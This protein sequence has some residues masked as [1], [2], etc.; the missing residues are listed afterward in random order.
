[1]V[2]QLWL[3]FSKMYLKK[4]EKIEEIEESPLKM[5]QIISLFEN[6]FQTRLTAISTNNPPKLYNQL[7]PFTKY[8]H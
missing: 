5:K 8:L 3:F 1:M 7:I 6:L 4:S 2:D